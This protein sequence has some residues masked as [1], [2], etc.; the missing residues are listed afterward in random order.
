MLRVNGVELEVKTII[1]KLLEPKKV[2]CDV[3]YVINEMYKRELCTKEEFNRITNT[4][5]Q[6]K[7]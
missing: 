5:Q 7:E 6:K 3:E 2:S 1:S 4:L